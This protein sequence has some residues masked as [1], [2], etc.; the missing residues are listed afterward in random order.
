MC[1]LVACDSNIKWKKMKRKVVHYVVFVLL[2]FFCV[3][4]L[5]I[6]ELNISVVLSLK[7]L[8]RLLKV[9]VGIVFFSSKV[10][11]VNVKLYIAPYI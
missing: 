5:S 9:I 8:I 10:L 1:Q 11:Q 2:S 3:F 6:T 7:D 4:L